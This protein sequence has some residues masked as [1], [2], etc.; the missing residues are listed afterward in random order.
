MGGALGSRRLS[1]SM[2]PRDGSSEST[3]SKTAS[4][5]ACTQTWAPPLTATFSKKQLM[6]SGR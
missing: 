5:E 2:S 3:Q 1:G 4:I 6:L